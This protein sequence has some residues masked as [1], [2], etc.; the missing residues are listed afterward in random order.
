MINAN[1]PFLRR[2]E[3]AKSAL[4]GG[5]SLLLGAQGP[6]QAEGPPAGKERLNV[7]DFGATGDGKTDDTKALQRA[8]DAAGE[9][10]GALFVPPGVYL[11]A[12]LQMRPNT[13]LLG[14][15]TWDYHQAGG[16]VLRLADSAA[17]CL[18]NIGTATGG[19][20]NGLGFD[21]AG[22]GQG[23]HGIFL[24]KPS[25]GK[26]EDA[27]RI[28]R[29][30]VAR[31]TGDGVN[32]AHAW[33]FSVRHSMLAYNQGDGLCLRGWD[34]FL[35]DNWFSGNRRAG[36]AAR[37]ENASVTFTANRVEWNGQEN[38]LIT[39]G[40][41]Y[42]ITGNFLDRA[43]TNGLALRNGRHL[44]MQKTITGNYFKR[45][46]KQAEAASH[47]SSHLLIEGAQGVTCV[48]NNFQSG[49]DD[50]GKGVW[51]PTHGI[52]CK[53][54]QNCVIANNVMH[55]GALQQLIID[56]GE[57]GEGVVLKDNPGSLFKIPE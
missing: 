44:S 33:C 24:D 1:S 12:D 22:L 49:R 37:D 40:D 29:C 54:L 27:F 10:Q 34:G 43:G 56:L 55:E 11:C 50:G 4:L 52:V 21:G 45:S 41:G 7:R 46:G 30:Q 6:A 16:T 17:K 23:I 18:L 13:A 39:G 36:F 15:P 25:Y 57:H 42:Q 8:L 5:A 14:I 2:R 3:M 9:L 32:L 53:N 48:G 51:S 35:S 38:V 47:D 26:H 31:F 19:T 20:I 28:E